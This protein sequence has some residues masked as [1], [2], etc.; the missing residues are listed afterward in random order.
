MEG[1]AL[2]PMHHNSHGIEYGK[3]DAVANLT[4]AA[5]VTPI[6]VTLMALAFI[7]SLIFC[8][9]GKTYNWQQD[10]SNNVDSTNEERPR[11]KKLRWLLWTLLALTILGLLIGYVGLKYVAII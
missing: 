2:S 5:I 10:M 8:C 9:R 7:C 3:R 1:L 6:A 11:P 4:I